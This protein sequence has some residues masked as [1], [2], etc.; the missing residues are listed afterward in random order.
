MSRRP[1]APALGRSATRVCWGLALAGWL[2][3]SSPAAAQS[4]GQGPEIDKVLQSAPK[5]KLTIKAVLVSAGA[6]SPVPGLEAQVILL[7]DDKPFKQ[8][9]VLLDEH[10]AGELGDLPVVM[11]VVPLVRL[12]YKGLSYVERATPMDASHPNSAVEV[13]VYESTTQ[14][15]AW[16][17]P[18]RHVMAKSFGDSVAVS[19]MVIVENPS[20]KTWVG[21]D[22]PDDKGNR[23]V[24]ELTLPPNAKDVNLDAGFHGW[25]CTSYADHQLTI[26]MPLM[27]GTAQFQFSYSVPASPG[28]TPLTFAA[29][30]KVDQMMF[31][32]PE[33]GTKVSPAPDSPDLKTSVSDQEGQKVRAFQC[34]ALRPGQAAGLL[35]S[36]APKSPTEVSQAWPAQTWIIGGAGALALGGV[37]ILWR[38]KK[39]GAS[40]PSR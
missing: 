4:L 40:A 22:P 34:D 23:P 5:G 35:V 6:S 25:C 27:P 3:S 2:F 38:R 29:P 31:L 15:P 20:D 24:V 26:K 30:V 1:A 8:L 18:M 10:G 16:H 12:E 17:I 39:T 37:A 14:T 13:K 21:R 28:G 11:G 7:H 33:D 36:G 32:V 9:K 19:E